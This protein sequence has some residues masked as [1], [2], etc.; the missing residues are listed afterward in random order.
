MIRASY[1]TTAAA[2]ALVAASPAF[3][4]STGDQPAPGGTQATRTTSYD[5]DFFAQ[6]AP[7]TALD[8]ARR[9]P[10][11][12]LDLGNVDIRGF[13]AAAGNVVINGARPS[14]KAETLETTLARIPARRVSK[15]EIG[16]GDLYGA[17]YS[18]KSQVL[19]II[20][21]AEG[22]I[23]GNVTG[24]VRRL[25]TGRLVPDGS[26]SA[27]IRRGPSSFNRHV[28]VRAV[29]RTRRA[30]AQVQQLSGLQSLSFSK[31]GAR[32]GRRQIH[33]SQR[34]LVARPIRPVSA[35]PGNADWRAA[36][37]RQSAAGL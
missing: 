11:F 28:D 9:V 19:N 37:R 26:A 36:A 33:A 14:S 25:Y 35:E 2:A 7:R 8:I 30:P 4:Q 23:D 31:L 1:L 22:G 21:S 18:T 5:A 17:D 6:Y 10:G 24:S 27:L 3:A 15:V 34:A 32:T 20:L 29:R 13:A 12:N 16:P